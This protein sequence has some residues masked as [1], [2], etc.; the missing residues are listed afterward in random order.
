MG[1]SDVKQSR[2]RRAGVWG[3]TLW[4]SRFSVCC[5][6]GRVRHSRENF[7]ERLLISAN[8]TASVNPSRISEIN[9]NAV[10]N[11]GGD[12]PHSKGKPASNPRTAAPVDLWA[13]AFH[14][15]RQSSQKKKGVAKRY[16]LD[17]F[18]IRSPRAF[19]KHNPQPPSC[20]R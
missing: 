17:I 2:K 14:Q 20:P 12:M 7:R 1:L 16:T 10:R 3:G 15:H 13:S 19:S 9:R 4:A 11:S 8:K 5:S 18:T 6:G